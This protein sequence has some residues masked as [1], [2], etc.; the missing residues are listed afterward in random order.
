[1][2]VES[3]YHRSQFAIEANGF[4][5]ALFQK[6][7]LPEAEI[8]EV[9]FSPAGSIADQKVAGRVKYAD[10]ALEKGVRQDGADREALNWFNNV[11]GVKAGMGLPEDYMRDVDIVQYNRRGEETRRWTLH[12][13]WIKK[14]E[15]GDVEGSSNEN[16]IEIITLTYQYYTEN[17]QSGGLG[18]SINIGGFK[19]GL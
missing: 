16:V 3:L 7:K 13:C 12:G 19:I 9:S 2:S 4:D 10:I 18:T 11:L 17:G 6:A 1:M 8:E 14:L 15:Y 5:L